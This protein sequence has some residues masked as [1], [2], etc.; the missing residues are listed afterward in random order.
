MKAKR[1]FFSIQVVM[2][3]LIIFVK[4]C[5]LAL[6]ITSA[7]G[8]FFMFANGLVIRTRKIR[9]FLFFLCSFFLLL[10]KYILGKV[11]LI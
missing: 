8:I 1:H 6:L 9:L 4:P 10:K 11:H 7:L 3:S 5:Q 2:I